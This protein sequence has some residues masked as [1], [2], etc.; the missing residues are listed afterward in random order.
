[1]IA[2]IGGFSGAFWNFL[3]ERITRF[4][5][6][7]IQVILSL[8]HWVQMILFILFFQVHQQ[9]SFLLKIKNNE[10]QIILEPA[11]G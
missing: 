9:T 5:M 1:M 10:I 7:Y 8:G 6:T 3:N 2:V 4:R 11:F